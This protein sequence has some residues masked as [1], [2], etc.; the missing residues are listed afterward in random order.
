VTY[1]PGDLT[2]EQDAAIAGLPFQIRLGAH[3]DLL[4]HSTESIA[5]FDEFILDW[6]PLPSPS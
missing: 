3:G 6:Q 2:T 1:S 5:A 4:D